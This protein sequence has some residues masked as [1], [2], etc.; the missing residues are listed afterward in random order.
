VHHKFTDIS[1][2]ENINIRV[3]TMPDIVSHST[4]GVNKGKVKVKLSLCQAMEAHRV[5]RR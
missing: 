4:L 5:V 2:S 3:T 1:N